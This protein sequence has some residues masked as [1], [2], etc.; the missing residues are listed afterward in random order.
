[1][2]MMRCILGVAV[3]V[4]VTVVVTP[5]GRADDKA[6]GKEKGGYIHVVIF[7]MKKDAPSG[8]VDEVI[9]DC[10]KMLGK[11]SVVRSVKA[12]RPSK[13]VA[14]KVVKTNYDVGLL[15][16]VDDFDGIK[17]YLEDPLHKEFVKKHGKHFEITKLQV[18][19]FVN[20]AK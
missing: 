9:A 19:D 17:A 5:A 14:E 12:G 16:T 15:V 8:A 10:H 3:L 2:Q 7:T 1:M 6:A 11:I 20:E 13:Q 4:A 18:F